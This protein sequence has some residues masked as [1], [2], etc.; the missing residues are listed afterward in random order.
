[1]SILKVLTND[2][3]SNFFL[4]L[5]SILCIF[6]KIKIERNIYFRL[7]IDL[8]NVLREEEYHSPL[9][10]SVGGYDKVDIVIGTVPTASKSLKNIKHTPFSLPRDSIKNRIRPERQFGVANVRM[11]AISAQ[12]GQQRSGIDFNGIKDSKFSID[13]EVFDS[14]SSFYPQSS[15]WPTRLSSKASAGKASEAQT[16]SK[17]SVL[18]TSKPVVKP[19]EKTNI[20]PLEKLFTQLKDTLETFKKKESQNRKKITKL[21]NQSNNSPEGI[22]GPEMT[23]QETIYVNI[24]N[25]VNGELQLAERKHMSR[26]KFDEIESTKDFSQLIEM[27]KNIKVPYTSPTHE[28]Q[29]SVQVIT[30]QFIIR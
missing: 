10:D 12:P 22:S 6:S 3:L 27:N 1:M 17:P 26:E 14:L 24:W 15:Q 4:Q 8:L 21:L 19:A 9:K 23:A 7:L 18:T 20:E 2:R 30:I 16:T 5:K 11:S 25:N 28:F 13:A 29:H